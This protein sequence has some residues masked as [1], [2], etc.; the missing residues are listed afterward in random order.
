M[1]R[2]DQR[3]AR[4]HVRRI[5]LFDRVTK[6]D[7]LQCAPENPHGRTLGRSCASVDW[8]DWSTEQQEHFCSVLILPMLIQHHILLVAA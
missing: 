6:W 8:R 3:Q 7:M 5:Q 4:A 1:W 2:F